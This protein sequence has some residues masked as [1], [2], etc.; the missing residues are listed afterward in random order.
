M[1]P[2]FSSKIKALDG[3][4]MHDDDASPSEMKADLEARG[5]AVDTYLKKFAQTISEARGIETRREIAAEPPPKRTL[6]PEW[7]SNRSL[8][9]WIGT[10]PQFILLLINL[11]AYKLITGELDAEQRTMV[12]RFFG[13]ELLLLVGITA[14]ALIPGRRSK[15]LGWWSAAPIF[16]TAAGYLWI[17]IA[18]IHQMIPGSVGAWM[19]PAE[20][21]I[22]YQFILVMPV[23]FYTVIWMSCRPVRISGAM[24]A[25]LATGILVGI[26]VALFCA[27]HLVQWLDIH[28][29][30]EAIFFVCMVAGT[31]LVMAT[32]TRLCVTVFGLI[33]RWPRKVRR[34]FFF[35]VGVAA[36]LGGLWLNYTIPFPAEFQAWPVY[37]M[38]ALNGLVLMLPQGEA[39]GWA[40]LVWLIRCA[41]FPFIL[42]FFLLFIPF[43]PL[44]VIAMIAAGAGFL[45]LTPTVL[46]LLQGQQVLEGYRLAAAGW[47]RWRTALATVAAMAIMPGFFAV[48]AVWDRVVLRS[49]LDYVYSPD[50]RRDDQFSGSRAAVQ[51]S[52]VHL[53]DFKA[54]V[55]LPF[56]TAFYSWAVFDNLVLP[57]EKMNVM[58]RA[59]FGSNVPEASDGGISVFSGRPDRRNPLRERPS[60]A[61]PSSVK[62]DKL[63]TT[64]VRDGTC[65]RATFHLELQGNGTGQNEYNAELHIPEGVFISGLRLKIGEE[66][67]PGRLFEKKAAMW[68]YQK[69]SRVQRCDPAILVYRDAQTIDLKVFPITGSERRS[70]E[71]E[72]LYPAGT[73]PA[74][75]IGDEAWHGE[76]SGPASALTLTSEGTS[77]LTLSADAAAKLP[78]ATRTPYLHFIIDRSANAA[79]SDEQ[80]SSALQTAA[81]SF[82]QVT[83]GMATWTN[84]EFA[85]VASEPLPLAALAREAPARR[86]PKRGG[87][88]AERAI[89]RA[90]LGYHERLAHAA[91]GSLWLKRY[92]VFVVLG[93][94]AGSFQPSKDLASFAALAPDSKLIYFTPEATTWEGYNFAGVRLLNTEQSAKALA[95]EVRPVALLR[96]GHSIAPCPLDTTEPLLVHF[97]A[98]KAE[99]TPSVLDGEAFR[100][101]SVSTIVPPD[102]PYARG[103]LA[104][105]HCL[106][107]AYNPSLGNRGLAAIVDLSRDTGILLPATSY[108]VVENSAQWEMLRRKEKQKLGNQNALEFESVPE[109]TALVLLLAGGALLLMRPPRR[110]RAA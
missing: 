57:D 43:L 16:L 72:I 25:M 62:L 74:L 84:Y 89:E 109:P 22:Y 19:L 15:T 65:E 29:I 6:L 106:D 54:G 41:F 28:F 71:L 93:S 95:V 38:A 48:G 12:V 87:L 80:I 104:E 60:L 98:T 10:L 73:H 94:K 47:G 8:L 61:P 27:V 76:G 23:V 11:R 1:K 85:D 107:L 42:Y 91:P 110:R 78:R 55:Q 13:L 14:M 31:V 33:P 39:T 5:F 83:E 100:P 44:F 36:P 96:V 46:F 86:L 63:T 67:V 59:F 7:L 101:L 97:E 50:L 64:T 3:L 105:Q 51:R 4:L 99:R 24:E 92:P 9:L 37:V 18:K 2:D 30:P 58:H 17:A 103:T 79:L 53:R 56:L 88:L 108:I 52:L 32:V 102:A 69:I 66:W 75:K 68:V 81:A 49:A 34:I 20:M 90:L 70:L 35:L 40:R 21:Q 82:P 77:T 45:I 26:P